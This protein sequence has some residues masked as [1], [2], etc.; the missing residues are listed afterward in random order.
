MPRQER[1]LVRD[2]RLARP[3]GVARL[4]AAAVRAIEI[5]ALTYGSVRSILDQ[6]LDRDAVRERATGAR[7][8][9]I[10]T[11]AARATTIRRANLTHPS[12]PIYRISSV[13]PAWPTPS[14][15]AAML[16]HPEWLGLLL[17]PEARY[18]RDKR[19]LARPRNARLRHQASHRRC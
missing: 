1:N 13:L 19:L 18:R 5:R 2:A 9:F 17:D 4:E 16:T 12:N 7:R 10:P 8:S 15:E 11:S 14:A 3:F 6:K